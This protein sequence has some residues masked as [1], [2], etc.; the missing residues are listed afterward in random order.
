MNRV[1]KMMLFFVASIMVASMALAQKLN[2]DS[3]KQ[4]LKSQAD[5]AKLKTLV[6][7]AAYYQDN[8]IDSSLFYSKELLTLSTATEN[9]RGMSMAY[10]YFGQYEY[11]IGNY[12]QSF[13]LLFKGLELAESINDTNRIANSHNLIGNAYKEYGDW[14]K[15]KEYFLQTRRLAELGNDPLNKLFAYMNL[16]QAYFWLKQLDSALMAEQTAYSLALSG[17]SIWIGVICNRLANIHAALNNK[18]LALQYYHMAERE[19]SRTFGNSRGLSTCYRDLAGFYLGQQFSDSAIFYAKQS[20]H[21]AKAVPYLRGIGLA[22]K[23]LSV[24]YESRHQTDSAFFYQKIYVAANDSLNSR[25]KTSGVENLAFLQQ[26]RTQEK[27]FAVLKQKEERKNN[28]QMAL[29]AIGILTLVIL[30]VLLSRSIIVSHKLV[31]FLGIVVLL[32]VFEFINL[33][34]HPYLERITGHS[35]LLLLLML[36]FIAALII[37]LHHRLQKWVTIRMVEKNKQ[38]RLAAA[39]KMI[40]SLE[41]PHSEVSKS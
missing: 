28:L 7:L 19:I 12:P 17:Q 14:H 35:P 33:F 39:R 36:V 38:I 18:E 11:I 4:A 21:V 40:Q 22:G 41:Q 15:A 3:L 25:E 31:E 24:I 6:Q 1:K 26:L 30:F 8:K 10:S 29:I 37:P 9:I 16:G 27:D 2:I 32:I 20:M 34:L 23:F 13:Q 5:T